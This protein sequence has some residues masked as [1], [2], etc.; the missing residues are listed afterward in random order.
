MLQNYRKVYVLWY[1]DFTYRE[2][3]TQFV[4]VYSGRRNAWK[5]LMGFVNY[6]R[7]LP[8][9]HTISSSKDEFIFSFEDDELHTVSL[10]IN[11]VNFNN[12]ITFI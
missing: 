11:E 6:Y 5:S 3:T 8:R 7:V 2:S 4:G 10:R 12:F 1:D 9:Y